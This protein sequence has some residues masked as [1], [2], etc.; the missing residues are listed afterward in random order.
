MRFG[1]GTVT[2]GGNGLAANSPGEP[3]NDAGADLGAMET[4]A[5]RGILQ[6]DPTEI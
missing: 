3:P 5:L 1:E 2:G 4:S 6:W